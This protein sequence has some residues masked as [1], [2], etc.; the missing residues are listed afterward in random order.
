MKVLVLTDS[1]L[2]GAGCALL[3]KWM[4]SEK[5]VNVNVVELV[6]Q[7]YGGIIKGLSQTFDEYKT[8]FVT[9][10]YI[11]DDC[12]DLLDRPNVYIIDHHADHVAVKDRYTKA[13]VL[14]ENYPSCSKLIMDK[15]SSK[16]KVLNDDRI[17]FINLINDYDS[18]TLEFRETLMINAI[19][20]A[21][22]RPKVNKLV[23]AFYDGNREF[24]QLEKNAISIYFRKVRKELD[25]VDVFEGELKG[26][27]VIS[28]VVH[29]AVNEVTHTLLKKYKADVA[30]A[31]MLDYNSVSFRRSKTCDCKLNVL[32][33]ALC[34]GGGHEY[35]A[36]G[37]ITNEFMKFTERLQSC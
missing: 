31:V 10:S 15:F 32:A 22:S 29:S 27:K 18:Y 23:E 13:N 16:I 7:N 9:D 30:I 14:V 24:N 36:G 1:D 34:G 12:V 3:I 6:G 17:K 20:S 5:D 2:D 25:N 11:P 8:I 33:S 28:F 37:K 21:Y 35:A 19:F 26:Y 4:Y